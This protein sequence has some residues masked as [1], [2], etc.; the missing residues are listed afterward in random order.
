MK[1]QPPTEEAEDG[2]DSPKPRPTEKQMRV[3]IDTITSISGGRSKQA[4][5]NNEKSQKKRKHK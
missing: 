3:N 2:S 1:M 5:G 4:G